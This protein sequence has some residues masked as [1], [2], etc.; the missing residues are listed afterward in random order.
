MKGRFEDLFGRNGGGAWKRTDSATGAETIVE[1]ASAG[2]GQKKGDGSGAGK[3][4][5][6]GRMPQGSGKAW[7]YIPLAVLV[8]VVFLIVA[9][10]FY[11]VSEQQQAV[12]TLFGRVIDI[13]GA[14]LYFK[15]PIAEDVILVD[16]TTKGMP[17]GYTTDDPYSNYGNSS[18]NDYIVNEHEAVMITSDFNFVDV[19]FYLEYRV[20]DPQ[21]YLYA[22]AQ[23]EAV[24]K[25]LAQACIRSTVVDY[26]V[27]DVI[28]TGKS[29]IQSEVRERL[30]AELQKQDIG[31]TVVNMTV[32][33]AEPPTDEVIAAFKA[34]ETAKQGKETSVNN[35]KRYQNEQIP[36]AEAEADQVLQQAEA[37][38]EAR[39]AE[40]EGQAERFNRIYE[41]YVKYPD[42]TKKRL[43]YETME[44][45]LPQLKVI[46]TDGSVQSYLPLTG[47]DMSTEAAVLDN[48]ETAGE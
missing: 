20:S 16:T 19:D 5:A 11:K 24:L 34:V 35:A 25:N 33:D 48:V 36:Q 29:Q 31:L 2:E 22:S 12:V 4:K 23:P 46:V 32:Q 38:K 28:T 13:K 27:D 30:E 7:K 43:F 6:K 21:K 15:I 1:E 10:S 9:D 40:A 18:S 26:T 42:V 39:I 14:G 44:D 41:E 8:L 3:K 37:A 47:A 45:V 17:I